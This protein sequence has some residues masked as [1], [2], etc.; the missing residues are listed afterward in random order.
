MSEITIEETQ[1]PVDALI[2]STLAEF[3]PDELAI[4]SIREFGNLT[5]ATVGIKAVTEARK[6]V[7]R[8]RLEIDK[9]RKDLN[10]GALKYQRAINA[11]A[12]RLIAEI[13]PIE[14]RLSAEEENYEAEKLREKQAKEQAKREKLQSRLNR[15]AAIGIGGCDIA[16]IEAMEDDWF[17]TL[18]RT[19]QSKAE[20]RLQEERE[21]Q[22]KIRSEAEALRSEREKLEAERAEINRIRQENDRR[23]N[24]AREAER[25]AAEQARL[26]ALKPEIEKAEAF[27]EALLTDAR[28]ELVRIGSPAW[29]DQALIEVQACVSEIV[30]IVRA[31][32]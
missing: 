13:E 9:R 29:G 19:E 10:E 4:A 20:Q 17:E 22:E 5:V 26:D 15:L 21:R 12:K 28:D 18:L 30:R 1:A 11:E 14:G 7:K 16:A 32:R 23:E 6:A 2:V 3:R 8:L 25:K 24:E 27:G 31:G